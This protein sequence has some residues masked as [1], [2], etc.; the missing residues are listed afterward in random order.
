MFHSCFALF[1]CHLRPGVRAV[2]SRFSYE[3]VHSIFKICEYVL[4]KIREVLPIFP[5]NLPK[6]CVP[7]F[8]SSPWEAALKCAQKTPLK[9]IR[10]RLPVTQRF[11]LI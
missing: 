10:H 5:R 2:V 4:K 6:L 8:C 3:N 9:T 1:I 7:P 11:G